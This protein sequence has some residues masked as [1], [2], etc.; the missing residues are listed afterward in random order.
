MNQRQAKAEARRQEEQA[1]S[2]YLRGKTLKQI[3]K[4][5]TVDAFIVRGLVIASSISKGR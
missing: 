1:I 4:A 5:T 2:M 3:K